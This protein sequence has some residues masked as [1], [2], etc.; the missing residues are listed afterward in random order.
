[1]AD[2][3]H[4][5]DHERDDER[6]VVLN[7]ERALGAPL[8]RAVVAELARIRRRKALL[9]SDLWRE[10]ERAVEAITFALAHGRAP[11]PAPRPERR[12][13]RAV[14]W[15]IERGNRLD[16]LLGF[17]A[18]QPVLLDADVVL[19]NE[20]DVGMARSGNRHV[21]R[22]I[23]ERFGFD[24]VFGNSYLCLGHGDAR[25]GAPGAE[26]EHGLHGNAI[27]SRHPIVRAECFSVAVTKDKFESSEKRLGHKKALWAELDTPLGRLPFVS[28]HLDP[29]ASPEQRRA[30]MADAR[31]TIA[32][33]RLGERVLLAGDLNTTTYDLESTPA[34]AWNIAK[35]LVRGGFPHAIDHYMRPHVLYER[36]MFDDLAADGFAWEP[37]NDMRAGSVR[38]EVGTFDSESKIKDHLPGF[39]A[40]LLRWKLRPWNGVAPLKIDWFVGR[41]L[42]ALGAGDVREPC[43]RVSVAPHVLERASHEGVRIS[44]HDPMVVD[45][46]PRG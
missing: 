19:L 38:Y 11:R 26:N 8:E 13:L 33:R 15:N 44:D 40:S 1:M 41:G 22:E 17:F 35:K 46:V 29:Y 4:T 7:G 24:W 34:L 6:V 12:F 18:R 31:R 45:V 30:Q 5:H 2:P 10:H 21:A 9:A 32:R 25:D 39:V 37:F 3:M 43:G 27:L 23:A 36:A 42:D 16:A 14:T 28:V 20:V